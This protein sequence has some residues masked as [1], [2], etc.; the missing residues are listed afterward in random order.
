[1]DLLYVALGLAALLGGGEFLVSGSVA[2]A[3]RFRVPPMVIGLTLVGFGTSAPELFTSLQAA[4]TGAPGIALGN[5]VGSNIANILLILGVA[6]VLRPIPVNRARL[7]RD[8]LWL[9]GSAVL[10]AVLLL[11]PEIGRLSGLVLFAGLV[12]FLAVTLRGDPTAVA[13]ETE[14]APA[15]AA[16]SALR[17]AGGLALTLLGA[18][19]L[20]DGATGI[21]RGL[22]V[23]EAVI[24][25]TLVAVGT[26]LPELVTSVMAARKGH[27]DVALGN[28]IGSNIFNILGILGITAL[29]SPLP[30]DAGIAGFDIWVMLAATALLMLVATTGRLVAR[31]EGAALLVLYVAYL[32]AL[33]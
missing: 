22:G 10:L 11:S 30:V 31:W 8:G 7:W 29:V 23:S 25:L 19:L 28:V 27:G 2:L 14:V 16:A 21:A 9:G 15:S 18:V 33:S 17:F 32:V 6:A 13:P 3:Q 5:V 1:M 12:A 4:R 26:S 20:V 24:G